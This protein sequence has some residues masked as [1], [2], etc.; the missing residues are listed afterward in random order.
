[1]D[2]SLVIGPDYQGRLVLTADGRALTGLMVEDNEQRVVLK[3]QG[4]KLE[5]IPRDD[6]EAIRVSQLSLMPEGLEKQLSEQELIDLFAY[7][8]LTR[9]PG[10][11]E[12]EL[13]PGAQAIDV[14]RLHLPASLTNELATAQLS[15]NAT[16]LGKGARGAAGDL[17]YLPNK[18]S[19]LQNSQW[20]EVGVGG[21]ADLGIVAEANPV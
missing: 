9:P 19:F 11:P 3:L 8:S 2:P 17:V 4:G 21:G 1:F 13:I 15:S 14:N 6:V 5:T 10:D 16:Q 7:L 18:Q 20:H 12:A